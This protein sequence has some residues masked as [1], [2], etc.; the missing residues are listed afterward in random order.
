MDKT[1]KNCRF[2][3]TDWGIW[4]ATGWTGDGSSGF[5]YKEPRKV[6]VSSERIGCRFFESK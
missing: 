2:Y 6:R 4:T 5:C 1:C 3:K